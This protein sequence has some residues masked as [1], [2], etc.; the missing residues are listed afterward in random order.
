MAAR[1]RGLPAMSGRSN[2]TSQNNLRTA[3]LATPRAVADYAS[4]IWLNK[5]PPTTRDMIESQQSKCARVITGCLAPTN[6]PALLACAHLP[7]LRNIA[8]E[9]AT[10]QREKILRLPENTPAV[11][12]AKRKT[13]PRLKSRS[14]ENMK[15]GKNAHADSNRPFRGCWRRLAEEMECVET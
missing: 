8:Q 5:A 3:Y 10:V 6:T 2:G 13:Q 7:P 1:R 15:R 14:H 9:R 11:E 4:A 12:V